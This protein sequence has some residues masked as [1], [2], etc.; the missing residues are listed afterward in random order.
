MPM[1][2]VVQSVQSSP[3]SA[4]SELPA[5]AETAQPRGS[6]A[7]ANSAASVTC[8]CGKPLRNED[9][10]MCHR[11][12]KPISFIARLPAELRRAISALPRPGVINMDR[13][14]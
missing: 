8:T 9:S 6:R 14:P 5:A 12:G 2:D 3:G 10:P 11:C 1:S 4:T 7:A 13:L